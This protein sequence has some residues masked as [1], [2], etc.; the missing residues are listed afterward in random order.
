MK[1]RIKIQPEQNSQRL[2]IRSENF[3]TESIIYTIPEAIG[4]TGGSLW[5]SP[6]AFLMEPEWTRAGDGWKY[7][8][9]KD[10]HLSF[11]VYAS[12]GEDHV[13]VRIRLKNL[14]EKAWPESQAFSCLNYESMAR[15]ADF[16][17]NRTFLLIDGQWK[18]MTE[19]ERI[20]GS[21]PTI[22][23]W[24]VNGKS[25]PLGFVAGYKST[26]SYYPEGVLAVRSRD[27]K[28]MIAVSCDNP[29]YL[30]SNLE[31]SCI[32][33]CPS[34]G[35]LKPGEEGEAFHRVFVLKDSSL[36]ELGVKLKELWK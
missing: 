7:D 33:S 32:H 29:L 13:D 2:I 24:Y 15:L 19:V 26:P 11:S 5:G 8:W 23:L 3:G 35:A 20:T 27:G 16:E 30:F 14:S 36:D 25:R 22:Q 1:D 31:F 18:T 10:G 9:A 12:A 21:R 28:N 4:S 17:G 6:G 34:F